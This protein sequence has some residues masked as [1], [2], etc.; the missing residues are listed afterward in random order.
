M[1]TSWAYVAAAGIVLVLVIALGIT[2]GAD[3]SVD[4]SIGT[5]TATYIEIDNS[6][7][8]DVV[9]PAA[10]TTKAGLMSAADK[11]ILDHLASESTTSVPTPVPTY[12]ARA[13]FKAI[14]DTDSRTF[15]GDDFMGTGNF[16]VSDPFPPSG[17]G[18]WTARGMNLDPAATSS[19]A[20]AVP[21]AIAPDSPSDFDVSGAGRCDQEGSNQSVSQEPL[22]R[23]GTF[24]LSGQTY[25]IFEPTVFGNFFL[26]S[27]ATWTGELTCTLV[28]R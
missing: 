21:E 24:D 5:R 28:R 3:L 10:E 2:L 11:V 25:V 1:S 13:A 20:Y 26:S 15:V 16:G 8:D 4:L 12:R 18:S 17:D 7:G 22:R 14:T 19:I 9:I 23:G 27:L 6:A